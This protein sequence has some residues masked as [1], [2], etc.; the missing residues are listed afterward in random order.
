MDPA[1]ANYVAAPGVT[2]SA[3]A[4]GNACSGM[5]PRDRAREPARRSRAAAGRLKPR[6]RC[7]CRIHPDGTTRALPP[8]TGDCNRRGG[9]RTVALAR[10]GSRLV[11]TNL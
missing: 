9:V 4:P 6:C 8:Q 7:R 5:A 11:Q 1:L 3:D 2:L 10:F